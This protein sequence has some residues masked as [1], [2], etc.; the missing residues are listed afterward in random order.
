MGGRGVSRAS[1]IF[2]VRGDD[3]KTEAEYTFWSDKTGF[4]VSGIQLV[5]PG[6]TGHA[7]VTR[8][9]T[10]VCTHMSR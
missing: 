1:R 6:P 10:G 5:F 9:L 7:H 3:E 4:C 2:R 8:S